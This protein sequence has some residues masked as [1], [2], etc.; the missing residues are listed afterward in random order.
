MPSTSAK[1]PFNTNDNFGQLAI[2]TEN[3]LIMSKPSNA[4][5]THTHHSNY[6]T[7][8]WYLPSEKEL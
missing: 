2:K 6:D 1:F 5:T 3:A 7:M 8:L 4:C